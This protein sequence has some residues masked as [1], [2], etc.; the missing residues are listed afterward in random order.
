VVTTYTPK[1]LDNILHKGRKA[2]KQNY[3]IFQEN[4]S[5]RLGSEFMKIVGKSKETGAP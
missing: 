4:L 1:F 3:M 5:R 2:E